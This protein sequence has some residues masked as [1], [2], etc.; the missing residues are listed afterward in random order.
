MEGAIEAFNTG[1]QSFQ[2]V[3]KDLADSLEAERQALQLERDNLLVEKQRFAAEVSRIEQVWYIWYINALRYIP[4][5]L[6]ILSFAR[7]SDS[8][9]PHL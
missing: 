3:L 9:H 7:L 5:A 8:T 4:A 6:P 2:T 1:T